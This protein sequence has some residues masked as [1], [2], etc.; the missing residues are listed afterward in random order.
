MPTPEAVWRYGQN[1]D[2]KDFSVETFA[3]DADLSG[4][5][6]AAA[7]ARRMVERELDG[8]LPDH[9]IADVSLLVTELIANGVRHGGAGDDAY[10]HLLLAGQ[11]Q[12]LHVE[13]RNP[14]GGFCGA[15]ARRAPD[16]AGGGGIGLNLIA[17]MATRWGVKSVPRTAVWFELD[18]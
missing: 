1:C 16:L 4:G 11:R 8:R 13:V 9:V 2:G 17:A 3:V 18:C 12:G 7:R 10:L 14:D 5:P 6:G 15:P